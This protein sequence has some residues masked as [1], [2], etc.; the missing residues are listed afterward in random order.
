MSSKILDFSNSAIDSPQFFAKTNLL[1]QELKQDFT[2]KKTKK[3]RQELQR[4]EPEKM[5]STLGDF[6]DYV[7]DKSLPDNIEK[8]FSDLKDLVPLNKIE[9]ALKTKD[10]NYLPAFE[11]AKQMF[12]E[13]Q[14]FLAITDQEKRSPL[15]AKLNTVLHAIISFLE[16]IINAFGIADFFKPPEN[17]MQANTKAQRIFTLLSLFGVLTGAL[18]PLLGA[19]ITA[20]IVGGV[21]LSLAALSI[22]Y[23]HIKPMPHFIHKTVNW[24]KQIQDQ[25][26]SSSHVN[27]KHLDEMA[28]ALITGKKV[29][30]FPMLIGPS[31]IGKTETA[32]AFAWAIEKG[33]YPELKGKKVFYINSADLLNAPGRAEGGNKELQ[34]LNEAMGRHRKNIILIFDEIH[35]LCQKKNNILAEQLKTYLDDSVNG[36]VNVIGI[37][38]QQ[39]F[40]RDIY[41]YNP[42]FARRFKQIRIE[43]PQDREI[44]QTLSATLMQKLP[45]VI[46]EDQ[47]LIYLQ[48]TT[49]ETFPE[50]SQPAAAIKI[51]SQCI[52][53]LS[54]TQKSN[55]QE[56]VDQKRQELDLLISEIMINSR[57]G[58]LQTSEK[59]Q[60]SIRSAENELRQLEEQLASLQ[61]EIERLFEKRE[62]FALL[63]KKV[64]Q[65]AVQLGSKK[66]PS[67]GRKEKELLQEYVL[68]TRFLLPALEKNITAQAESLGLRVVIDKDLIDEMIALE[69][70]DQRRVHEA[71]D[72]G[73]SDVHVREKGLSNPSNP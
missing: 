60:E 52:K 42:A 73:K 7:V 68:S 23:P 3:L 54:E 21:L 27:T 6:F 41:R 43:A 24:S 46:L 25:T 64:C 1:I 58:F 59:E 18:L 61:K 55:L 62:K 16:S 69:L 47:A 29:K 50:A 30:S 56:K 37:T 26:L 71:I 28:K 67:L 39:E 20:P 63:K 51:L 66:N 12:K 33:I 11:S 45:G 72:A 40:Y 5:L 13:A 36:F 14:Y 53:S 48:K 17:D 10:S 34:R 65:I 22:I 70:E 44:Q 19:V 57:Q 31:G 32:K 49:Q 8:C 38:T 4:Q 35:I 15:S 2:I 9:E